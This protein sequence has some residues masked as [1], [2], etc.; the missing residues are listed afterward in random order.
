M[1]VTGEGSPLTCA[2]R[3]R[4]RCETP[5]G[6]RTGTWPEKRRRQWSSRLPVNA[7][8]ARVSVGGDVFAPLRNGP[9][10]A[11]APARR[12]EA[13]RQVT[14]QPDAADYKEEEQEPRDDGA[15]DEHRR[16]RHVPEKVRE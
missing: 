7:E 14:F 5:V 4:E 11:P 1:I 6:Q 9:E 2:P 8:L 10:D 12:G 15:G 3:E 13:R 16:R